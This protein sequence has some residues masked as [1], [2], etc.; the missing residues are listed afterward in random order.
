MDYPCVKFSNFSS[1][2]L[3]LSCGQIESH[4]ESQTDADDRCTHATTVSVSN[5]TA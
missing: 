2:I 5:Y 1:A 4:T 3:V